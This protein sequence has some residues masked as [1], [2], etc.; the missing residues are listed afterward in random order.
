MKTN[1]SSGAIVI[2]GIILWI[3]AGSAIRGANAT[4]S[5]PMTPEAIASTYVVDFVST[6]AFG[7]AINDAGDITGTSYP[8]PGCGSACLPTLETVVWKAGQRIVL[9]ALP[10]FSGATANDINNLGWI[11]GFGGLLGFG[12]QLARSCARPVV[13]NPA[14]AA[15]L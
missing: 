9:P 7:A 3:A 10:G 14:A 12:P 2:V 6:A 8:D 13:G 5:E 15:S 11:C 4:Q 1:R